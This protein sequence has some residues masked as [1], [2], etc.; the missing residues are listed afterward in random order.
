M[1]Y[2]N[3]FA[4]AM[5]PWTLPCTIAT[6][7]LLLSTLSSAIHAS[8]GRMLQQETQSQHVILGQ[9]ATELPE[10]GTCSW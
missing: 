10:L 1:P 5:A 4:P 8:V 2:A 3:E 6:T 7:S 9:E